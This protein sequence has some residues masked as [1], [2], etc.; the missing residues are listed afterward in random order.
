[1]FIADVDGDGVRDLIVWR[2]STGTWYALTSSSNYN[3]AS[4]IGKQWGNKSLGDVPMLTDMD[5]DGNADFTVWRASTGTFY[6]LTS[7]SR[8][9]VAGSR[10]GGTRS[11]G[12]Q[13]LSGD[14]DADGRSDLAVWRAS[15]GTFHWLTSSSGYNYASAGSRQWGSGAAGDVPQ[16][17]DVDGDGRTD[18]LVWRAPTG[19][20]FWLTSSSGYS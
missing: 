16:L 13:P 3:S 5:G 1:P 19:V 14:F 20:W 6:W 2:G 10:Q 8:Y 11:L 17:G 18:L 12:D 4:A 7:S 9:T 15:T